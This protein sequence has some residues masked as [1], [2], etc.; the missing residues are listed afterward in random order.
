MAT[1][2]IS[3][4]IFQINEKIKNI[5]SEIQKLESEKLRLKHYIKLLND[6]GEEFEI[7]NFSTK[8]TSKT[9]LLTQTDKAIANFPNS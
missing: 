6:H 5:E 1:T 8:M 2:N 4:R 7:Y 9:G 3:I